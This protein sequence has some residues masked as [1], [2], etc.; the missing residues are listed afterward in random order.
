MKKRWRAILLIA[1]AIILCLIAGAVWLLYPRTTEEKNTLPAIM[2]DRE[3][4]E[5]SCTTLEIDGTWRANLL[6]PSR[7]TFEGLLQIPALAYTAGES[8]NT[9]LEIDYYRSENY[10]KGG[11]FYK[12]T[13]NWDMDG[14]A[15][16]FTYP[17]H[18]V[19]VLK[20]SLFNTPEHEYIV[21][22][23]AEKE[24]EAKA[25]CHDMGL[26]YLLD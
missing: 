17:D 15:T 16:L 1:S 18:S 10:L 9:G 4:L 14:Y 8:W 23:P 13:G 19:Y 7:Q 20:T 11:C 24:E 22:A 3:T 6:S 26:D 25:I 21:V 5:I 12:T 2:F